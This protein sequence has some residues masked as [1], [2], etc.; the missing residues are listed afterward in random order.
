MPETVWHVTIP[1]IALMPAATADDA[2]RIVAEALDHAGFYPYEEGRRVF[3]SEPIEPT[4]VFRSAD[5]AHPSIL[6]GTHMPETVLNLA[7]GWTLRSDDGDSVRLCEPDGT[8]RIYWDQNEWHEDPVG[9]MAAIFGAASSVVTSERLA[10]LRAEMR[11]EG[12]EF[13]TCKA[14]NAEIIRH[15]GGNWYHW[16]SGLS[17]TAED[18]RD[19][20]HRVEPADKPSISYSPDLPD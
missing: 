6:K 7:N 12:T 14:C 10:E 11:A 9:V 16:T 1:A 5:H 8:E 18:P 2:E 17:G 15:P 3:E 19:P 4:P 13:S 20:S